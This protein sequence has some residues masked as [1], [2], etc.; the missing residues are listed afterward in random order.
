MVHIL[1]YGYT[2]I[3]GYSKE[4]SISKGIHQCQC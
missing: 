2:F 3:M 1:P 4:S